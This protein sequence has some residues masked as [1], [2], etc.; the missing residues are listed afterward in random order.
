MPL[1]LNTGI[2]QT[3]DG[4][5]EEALLKLFCRIDANSDGTID[6]DEF[7]SY[8]LLESQVWA[9]KGHGTH[10]AVVEGGGVLIN[11]MCCGAPPGRTGLKPEAIRVFW[12]EAQGSSVLT[13]AASPYSHCGV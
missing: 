4:G 3:E 13:L 8:M 9:L 12:F 11:V 7:S 2:L 5:D 6:W 10:W 1:P